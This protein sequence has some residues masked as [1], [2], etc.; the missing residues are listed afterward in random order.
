MSKFC[1]DCGEQLKSENAV[2]CVSCGA[3][4]G[5]VQTKSAW[6][7]SQKQ[8]F[9]VITALLPFIGFIIGLVGLFNDNNRSEGIKLILA[10]FLFWFLWTVI[11]GM[12]LF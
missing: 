12:I 1:S 11:F 8:T 7:N 9:F 10:S 3:G 6:S 4:Q 5:T 2:V